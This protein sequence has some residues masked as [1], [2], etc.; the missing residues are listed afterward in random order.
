M[1]LLSKYEDI[2]LTGI[3]SFEVSQFVFTSDPNEWGID[4][5]H[6]EH[7]AWSL[8]FTY[9]EKDGHHFWAQNNY[10]D[11]SL[12]TEDCFRYWNERRTTALNPGIR[13]RYSELVREFGSLFPTIEIEKTF[14]T[15][16]IELMMQVI[17]G[18]Y[19]DNRELLEWYPFLF[20]LVGKNKTYL[21]QAKELLKA[22]VE[23]CSDNCNIDERLQTELTI[24]NDN[25][26]LFDE[27]EKQAAA[28]RYKD[29]LTIYAIDNN[30]WFFYDAL[31][32]ILT[33]Y[34]K[35]SQTKVIYALIRKSEELFRQNG[36][37]G[38]QRQSIVKGLQE[39]YGRYQFQQDVQRLFKDIQ[40]ASKEA[41]AN[42][43]K[44][45]IP[46]DIPQSLIDKMIH[47]IV[48][49]ETSKQLDSFIIHF[50]PKKKDV[51]KRLE[52]DRHSITSLFTTFH[53]DSAGYPSSVVG[54]IE[55]DPIG[56]YMQD[57]CTTC[58][59]NAILMDM[60][61]ERMKESGV[62]TCENLSNEIVQCPILSDET[63]HFLSKTIVHYF[64]EEYAEFCYMVIPQIE[65]IIRHVVQE[66]D[67]VVIKEHNEGYQVKTLGELLRDPLIDRVYYI[68]TEDN[69]VSLYLQFL[70]SNDKGWNLRNRMCHGIE[71]PTIFE[72]KRYATHLMHALL[73]LTSITIKQ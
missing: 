54:S 36:H 20:S 10:P 53:Y 60:C 48:P 1:I 15:G 52:A 51:T 58:G 45:S 26:K 46:C 19:I 38:L 7:L 6:Y 23:N 62:W 42:M 64:Q 16:S 3:T 66:E 41:I 72:N 63:K 9:K 49:D 5:Y 59:I 61:I 2:K 65:H 17:A 30:D 11:M 8:N 71:E 34:H 67:G 28:E 25:W 47:Q 4:I 43:Q 57:L 21:P 40:E 50:I 68:G 32:P 24:I 18:N 22:Y 12:L 33:F 37:K 39:L 35:L 44:I 14:F 29:L 70:L 13:M 69:T 31:P 73:F 56:H 55:K 27:S